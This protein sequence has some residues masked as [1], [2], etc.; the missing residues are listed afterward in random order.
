MAGWLILNL[1]LFVSVHCNFEHGRGISMERAV[2]QKKN[3]SKRDRK[4][5][6]DGVSI[7]QGVDQEAYRK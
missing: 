6:S 4:K 3:K 1:D 2:E 5:G 7:Y